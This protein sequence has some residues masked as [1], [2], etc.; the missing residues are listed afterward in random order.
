[1]EG[2]KVE[3]TEKS[4]FR[5]PVVYWVNQGFFALESQLASRIEVE[6]IKHQ[7]TLR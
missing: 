1:M 5:G 4:P 6:P 3:L 7:P 2:S